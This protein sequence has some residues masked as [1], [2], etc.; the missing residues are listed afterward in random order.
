MR[1]KG[2]LDMERLH[3]TFCCFLSHRL[4]PTRDT[5]G[6]AFQHIDARVLRGLYDSCER[7]NRKRANKTMIMIT[8]IKVGN[9]HFKKASRE[10]VE[11][12]DTT[13]IFVC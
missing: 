4:S 2:Q 10:L 11:K 1:N 13:V 8:H 12:I 9:L 5:V 6:S 3:G 7:G